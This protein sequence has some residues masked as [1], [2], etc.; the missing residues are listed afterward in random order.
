[1]RRPPI[2]KPLERRLLYESQYVCVVCQREGCHVHHID[3]NHSNNSEKNLVVLCM[4]HHDEAHTKKQLSKNLDSKVLMDAKHRWTNVV[5]ERRELVA[6]VSGQKKLSAASSFLSAGISWGYINH[7]R[8]T[9]MI[10]PAAMDDNGA[11]NFQYCVNKGLVDQNAILIKPNNVV[12]SSSYI[13][14]TIYDWFDFGDD[15]R[16]HLL[17]TNL[18]DQIS[19]NCDVVYLEPESLT[20][21]RIKDLISPGSLIFVDRAFYFKSV[22]ETN[23][24]QHRRCRTFKR[25]ISIK[26]FADTRNM[27]GTTSITVSFSGHKNCAALVQLKSIEEISDGS[28]ILHCTPIALGVGFKAIKP[29]DN[30]PTT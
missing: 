23:E 3:Q 13:S 22:K 28:L 11:S 6:T 5:R 8:V 7:K 1:M 15:Q 10:N 27:F 25:K 26:F 4:H 20:K 21:E 18:V 30:V 16:L 24:N 29:L 2:P 14:N 9:Q 17:Y 19:K 12:E